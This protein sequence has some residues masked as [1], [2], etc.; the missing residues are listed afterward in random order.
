MTRIVIAVNC[1]SQ[2]NE[3]Q[4]WVKVKSQL[5]NKFTTISAAA[6]VAVCHPNAFRLAV[7][8]K[9]PRIIKWLKEQNVR[10]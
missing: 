3:A 1:H 2:D 4:R 5:I 7:S 6:S 8:G 9:C 10:I